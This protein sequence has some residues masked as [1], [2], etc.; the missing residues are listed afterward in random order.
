MPYPRG[1]YPRGGFFGKLAHVAGSIIGGG[2]K[3]FAKSGPLG[4]VGGVL[5]GGAGAIVK[6]KNDRIN[7]ITG[8]IGSSDAGTPAQ[9]S[10]EE[11]LRQ[12]QLQVHRQQAGVL[13]GGG[14]MAHGHILSGHRRRTMRVTNVKALRRALRRAEGFKKL[15]MHTIRLI[16][17][18]LKGKKFGGF[19][20]GRRK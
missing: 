17:P 11:T 20:K 5:G 12:H 9:T 14:V 19:K 18:N 15:A 1:D 4:L 10:P 13:A 3:G 7:S 16:S 2:V 8:P 6:M